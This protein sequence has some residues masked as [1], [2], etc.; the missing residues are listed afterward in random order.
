M[1]GKKRVKLKYTNLF[2]LI[3]ILYIIVH[4]IIWTIGYFTKTLVLETQEISL[5]INEK[6]LV[7][8]EEFVIK[9]NQKGIVNYEVS[10]G[11]KIKRDKIMFT[12]NSSN[13]NQ[14][15]SSQIR[16]LKN[17]I[18][19]LEKTGNKIDSNII[20]NK[21]EQL[22]ILENKKNNYYTD[23]KSPISGV[24][25]FKYDDNF[26][27]IKLDYINNI[28]SKTISSIEN[29][30][31][32]IDI[33]SHKV[34]TSDILI[35]IVNS[36]EVYIF[37]LTDKR[38]FKINQDVQ[39]EFNNQ[40]IN[41][42]VY[43]V[44]DKNDKQAALIKIMEQNMPLYD[45]RVKEFG[46]IYKKIEGFKIPIE[47]VVEKNDKLGVYVMNEENNMPKFV[48]LGKNYYNDEKYFYVDYNKDKDVKKLNL[49]DR[50][51]LY[52]NFINKNIKVSR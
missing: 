5:K 18:K 1:L 16:F 33:N 25:S 51:L 34:N 3:I 45:T 26:E 42:K 12:I 20:L 4:I 31:K 41:G 32:E 39:I 46:I 15:I 27:K 35:R 7:I 43:K 44:Y 49:Y 48:N 30:F 52:P 19:N 28:N 40:N 17:E 29:N 23:Y 22:K 21:K 13:Q 37:I 11:E 2:I 14:E 36:N 47:S 38:V 10:P 50:I 24:V 8:M 6:G 9:S